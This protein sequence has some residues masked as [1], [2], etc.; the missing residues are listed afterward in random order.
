MSKDKDKNKERKLT[1]TGRM[2]VAKDNAKRFGVDTSQY[3]NRQQSGQLYGKKDID[4]LP[5][6][7]AQAAQNNYNLRE[8][9]KYGSMTGHK[10][11]EDAPE[12]IGSMDDLAKIN[13]AMKTVHR[14]DLNRGGAFASESDYSGVSNEMA[15][16]YQRFLGDKFKTEM[17]E[18]DDLK[19]EAPAEPEAPVELSQTAQDTLNFEQDR[20]GRPDPFTST[21]SEQSGDTLDMGG[22]AYNPVAGVQNEESGQFLDNYKLNVKR[23]VQQAGFS[24][25]GPNSLH[26]K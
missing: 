8:S 17:P 24:S 26:N 13:K 10:A 2:R 21:T 12:T 20:G 14:K 1:Y 4:N 9:M 16:Q 15:Q 19:P 22:L 11:F 6:A 25:R 7:V 3:G 18:A 23:G 5:D